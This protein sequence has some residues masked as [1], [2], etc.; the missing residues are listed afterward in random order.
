MHCTLLWIKHS[1]HSDGV[2]FVALGCVM[3]VGF[4]IVLVEFK[5]SDFSDLL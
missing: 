1:Q 3:S 4:V 2:T 5:A